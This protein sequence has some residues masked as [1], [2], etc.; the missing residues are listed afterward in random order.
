M[1]LAIVTDEISFDIKEAIDY[2][3]SWNIR[4]F[5]LRNLMTGRVP[6]ITTEE[7]NILLQ[8]KEESRIRI[9]AVSPG[10]FKISLQ[11]EEQIKQE[12]EVKI[13]DSFRFAEKLGTRDVIISS[14]RRYPKEPSSNYIQIIHIL[15]RMINLAERYGFRLLIENDPSCWCDTAENMAKILEDID[16]PHLRAYWNPGNSFIA[17][18]IPYPYGFLAIRKYITHIHVNDVRTTG[19][20]RKEF[21]PIG[22]GNVDWHGQFQAIMQGVDL[23]YITI[24]TRCEPLMQNSKKSIQT[25]RKMLKDYELDDDHIIS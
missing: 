24:E 25:V 17:G 12:L 15:K 16:S 9:S 14:F 22:D 3:V 19:I 20:S 2:G 23:N 7:Q 8:I 21:V 13:Y 5:E 6:Y 4:D 10:L 11:Q 1:K 18:E